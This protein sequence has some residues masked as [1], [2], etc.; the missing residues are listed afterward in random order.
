MTSKSWAQNRISSHS[1]AGNSNGNG[2][3]SIS[4]QRHRL[5]H[6]LLKMREDGGCLQQRGRHGCGECRR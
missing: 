1:L 3:S 2:L 4:I 5:V 6:V